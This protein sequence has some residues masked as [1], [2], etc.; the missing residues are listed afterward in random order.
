MLSVQKAESLSL[1]KVNW[2]E[3]F[4]SVGYRFKHKYV[5]TNKQPFQ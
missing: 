1:Q 4:C 2:A 5:Y 3:L